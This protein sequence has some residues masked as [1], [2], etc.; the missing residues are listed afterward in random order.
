MGRI[1]AL[2]VALQLGGAA[3]ADL[4]PAPVSM[5]AA[6]GDRRAMPSDDRHP[7]VVRVVV[8]ERAGFSL[9]SGV[10]VA[11]HGD[12]G[13]VVTNWHV[14][15][16]AA[17]PVTVVFP[18]G[19]RSGATV[20]KTD[21]DWDLAALAIWRPQVEPIP[22]AAVAPRRGEPL[23]IIGYGRGKYRAATGRCVQYVAP[24]PRLPPELVELSVAAR[25]GDSGGPILNRRGELAGVLFGAGAGCTAG[26]YAGR[27]R[28]FLASLAPELRTTPQGGTMIARH[29]PKRIPPPKTPVASS[30]PAREAVA[31]IPA[32]PIA[33]QAQSGSAG[34]TKKSPSRPEDEAESQH[35]AVA[36]A[37]AGVAP[38]Q[39][40]TPLDHVKTFLALVGCVAILLQAAR[41]LGGQAA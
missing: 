28:Q 24:G 18:D 33:P 38:E 37:E 40:A 22:L 29:Q 12:R 36:T 31:S 20:L 2:A 30:T 39:P 23:T 17:G 21:K 25:Q 8:P 14:V 7:A 9:G 27:V 6:R 5:A 41:I 35:V 13:L 4:L 10:L 32:R 1:L 26:S 11:V 3:R 34:Q 15:S 16:E 19:F